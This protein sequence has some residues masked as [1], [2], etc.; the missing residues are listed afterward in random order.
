MLDQQDI[1]FVL[2]IYMCASFIISAV[3]DVLM[4]PVSVLNV[5]NQG[6]FIFIG[7]SILHEVQGV[8]TDIA[9]SHIEL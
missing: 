3:Y 2:E 7:I 8:H 5:C 1:K 6:L 4:I 9:T